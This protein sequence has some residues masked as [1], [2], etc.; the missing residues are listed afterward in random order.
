MCAMYTNPQ[1]EV[2][3]GGKATVEKG[4]EELMGKGNGP[5]GSG[6]EYVDLRE[7]GIEG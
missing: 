2:K 6:T 7:Q 4:M 5:V 3:R 1:S